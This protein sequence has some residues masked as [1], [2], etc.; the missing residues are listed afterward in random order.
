MSERHVLLMT[1]AVVAFVIGASYAISR[2]APS[3]G[4]CLESHREDMVITSPVSVDDLTIYLP[5]HM[6]SIVCD[7]RECPDG[8]R[9]SE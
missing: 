3:H 6:T 2:S 4:R 9:A 1:A 7:R 5:Q 8:R